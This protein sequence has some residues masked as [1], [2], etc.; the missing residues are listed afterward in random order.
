MKFHVAASDGA[1]S[2]T[3]PDGALVAMSFEVDEA[4]SPELT[5]C[6]LIMA[7]GVISGRSIKDIAEKRGVCA[8]QARRTLAGLRDS[9]ARGKYTLK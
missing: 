7:E 6:E 8:V 9:A 3:S 1:G 2:H 5:E 4:Q